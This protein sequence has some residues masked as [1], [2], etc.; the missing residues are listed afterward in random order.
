MHDS[1][2]KLAARI[3]DWV[4]AI[5]ILSIP[6]VLFYPLVHAGFVIDDVTQVTLNPAVRDFDIGSIFGKGYWANVTEAP[7]SVAAAGDLYR[8]L[9][10]L[11][12]AIAYQFFG[13]DPAG[14]H[15]ENILLHGLACLLL[16][17]LLKRWGVARFPALFGALLFAVAPIHIE[18]VAS[19]ILRNEL[20]AGILSILVLRWAASDRVLA[21]D[22][23]APL[24]YLAALLTKESAIAILFIALLADHVILRPGSER[25]G[26]QWR[27]YGVMLAMAGIYLVIR[28]NVLGQLGLS[29][30]AATYF[31]EQSSLIVWLTMARFGVE[32]YLS[33]AFLG[34]PLIYDYS[35]VSFANAAS[36]EPW[37]WLCL[38]FW[39]GLGAGGVYAAIRYR[40]R[41]TFGP[42]LF[43]LAIGPTANIVTRIG[44]IGASRLMY[45]PYLGIVLTIL[46]F[47]TWLASRRQRPGTIP[48][49]VACA[50]LMTVWFVVQTS[51]RLAPFQHSYLLQL[52]IL[53]H[54]P[55]NGLASANAGQRAMDFALDNQKPPPE[56]ADR[57]RDEWLREAFQRYTTG[58][59]ASPLHLKDTRRGLVFA[60]FETGTEAELVPTIDAG[61]RALY[62]NFSIPPLPGEGWS[63]QCPMRA[64]DR[65]VFSKWAEAFRPLLKRTLDDQMIARLTSVLPDYLEL[66]ALHRAVVGLKPGTGAATRADWARRAT[67]VRGRMKRQ[68]PTLHPMMVAV[69]GDRMAQHADRW[70]REI[71]ASK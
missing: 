50:T 22:L 61:M 63:R 51:R 1:P 27:M 42:L 69:F 35:L 62:P 24:G 66:Q 19:I 41:W 57:S 49:L 25:P 36:D 48:I 3:P 68:L 21:R 40:A 45:F 60:A 43:L 4:F 64:G 67:E 37:A 28:L 12:V 6:V 15:F 20:I 29:H 56:F 34:T 44:V 2:E 55:R 59:Q 18:P 14:Y 9:T 33:A 58:I 30:V 13:K 32:Q 47:G 17:G 38:V 54:A 70:L 23:L 53:A 8:P 65:V 46:A 5:L 7:Q 71:K 10:T 39:L 16:I 52:D 11:S 26:R 31:G